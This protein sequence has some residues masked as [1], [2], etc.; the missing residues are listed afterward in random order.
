MIS[1]VSNLLYTLTIIVEILWIRERLF[2]HPD[3]EQS[4]GEG[5]RFFAEFILSEILRSLR[6]LRMTRGEG[7]R[8]TG[9]GC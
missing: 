9:R 4:E 7:L 6:S 2:C 5:S 3:P 8:M 1:V